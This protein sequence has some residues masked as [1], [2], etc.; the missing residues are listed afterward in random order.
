MNSQN[1][2]V[3]WRV[4]I[5]RDRAASDHEW[6]KRY[7]NTLHRR[8]HSKLTTLKVMVSFDGTLTKRQRQAFS[9]L[10]TRDL[11]CPDCSLAET[12]KQHPNKNNETG[13]DTRWT[14]DVATNM[15]PSRH[16]NTNMFVWVSPLNF[17]E[18]GYG[19][20]KNEVFQYTTTN[21]QLWKKICP[22]GFE[23]AR[24]DR[25]GEYMS[26]AFDAWFKENG[27]E[28]SKTAP[29][30]SCG[31]AEVT[32]RVLKRRTRAFLNWSNAPDMFWDEASG[33]QQQQ[34][35]HHDQQQL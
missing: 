23:K 22:L 19:K 28:H 33:Q 29:G 20:H 24:T 1:K 18:V 13:S 30:S 15:P 26:H 16:G 7:A 31:V 32:I 14:S 21:Y 35:H 11:A 2:K 5:R 25:G 12:T 17:V 27:I 10:E 3:P 8:T 34:Q 4:K 6:A 9:Q